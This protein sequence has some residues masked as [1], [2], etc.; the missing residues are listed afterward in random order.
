V[1]LPA[2]SPESERAHREYLAG[3]TVWSDYE[4]NALT[5]ALNEDLWDLGHPSLAPYGELRDAGNLVTSEIAK[6][7]HATP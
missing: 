7:V 1:R 6:D 3:T 4:H 5:Q 2:P